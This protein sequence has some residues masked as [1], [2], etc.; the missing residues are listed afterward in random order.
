M[1]T[2]TKRRS[3]SY[4]KGRFTKHLKVPGYPV[5]D[6]SVDTGFVGEQT[7]TSTGHPF[8]SRRLRKMGLDLG[9]PFRTVKSYTDA[10]G[11]PISLTHDRGA[12]G[13]LT[14]A[15]TVYA[16]RST[17]GCNVS[18]MPPMASKGAM[19]G[20]GSI[21]ISRSLPTAPTA[22]LGQFLGELRE[23]LPKAIGQRALGLQFKKTWNPEYN[24]YTRGIHLKPRNVRAIARRMPKDLADEFLNY[25]FGWFPFVKDIK[26]T[27]KTY[28]RQSAIL[29]QYARDSG[30]NVRRRATVSNT[31]STT[32]TTGVNPATG[33]PAMNT[34]VYSSRGKLLTTVT[35]SRRVWTSC[36]FTYY[37]PSNEG[38]IGRLRQFEA[39]AAKLYGLRLTP[40]LLWQLAPWSWAADWVGNVGPLIKNWSAFAND[41]LVMRYGYVMEEI[42]VTTSYTLQ[43]TKL[44]N[45]ASLDSTQTFTQVSKQ[46]VGATPYGFGL[47][48]DGFS[49]KQWAIIAAL[50]IS[51]KPRSL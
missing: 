23:G 26:D 1:A 31:S 43:G 13:L 44:I 32:V 49:P 36:C 15:G 21:G 47:N 25:M 22:G 24:K 33:S 42:T 10:S 4:N 29:R 35:T 3:T 12:A 19:D 20:L 41:G 30:R 14:Y 7:T 5:Q 28:S 17:G 18:V 50:G 46:R 16:F 38:L 9:G 45:G 48:P 2:K 37:L 27:Y 8:H 40:H 11:V 34:A 6:T 51:R 39:K